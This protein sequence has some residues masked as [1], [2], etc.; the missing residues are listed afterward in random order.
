MQNKEAIVHRRQ[1]SCKQIQQ[2]R[3]NVNRLAV[4][5]SSKVVDLTLHYFALFQAIINALLHIFVKMNHIQY[6]LIYYTHVAINYIFIIIGYIVHF[7]YL[8]FSS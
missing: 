6:L 2:R 8:L 7:M 5:V 4:K 3:G 1:Y